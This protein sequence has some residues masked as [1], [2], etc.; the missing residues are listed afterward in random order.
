MGRLPS[1]LGRYSFVSAE[2]VAWLCARG[3]RVWLDGT[4]T[5]QSNPFVVLAESTQGVPQTAVS[6]DFVG[7][8]FQC[9]LE[10]SYCLVRLPKAAQG[11][12]QIAESFGE[13]RL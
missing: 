1:A 13:I 7:S 12:A 8:Q 9:L 2:P 10:A 5:E 3:S 6:L 11:I 4:L